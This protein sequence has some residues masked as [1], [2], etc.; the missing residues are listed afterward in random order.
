MDQNADKMEKWSPSSWKAKPAVQQPVYENEAE[1]ARVVDEVSKLPPLVTSWEVGARLDRLRST[2]TMQICSIL[3][4]ASMIIGAALAQQGL[5]HADKPTALS[6]C[7]VLQHLSELNCQTVTI[8]GAYIWGDQGQQMFAFPGCRDPVVRDCW[9]WR[10]GIYV[11]RARYND[12]A[13]GRLHQE[14]KALRSSQGSPSV[15]LV[16]LTGRLQ[17]REH[18]PVRK[19]KEERPEGYGWY[20][21]AALLWDEA[22]EVRVMPE[23]PEWRAFMHGVGVRPWPVR[24]K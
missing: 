19:Y 15:A 16:T 22:S 2:M 5:T 23:T 11:Y 3:A 18:F 21:A 6:F 8:T 24:A 4:L 1:V 12:P 9:S 14:I 10:P 17:T 20:F 7:D 13:I